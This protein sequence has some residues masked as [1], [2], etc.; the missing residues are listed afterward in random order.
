[1]PRA[2]GKPAR[3][4]TAFETRLYELCSA[5]PPGR[6]TTY[7]QMAAVLASAPRACGQVRQLSA[8]QPGRDAVMFPKLIRGCWLFLRR[9]G[10]TPLRRPCPATV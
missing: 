5:I 1:M 6:V 3:P 2:G 8:K 10:G 9:C 4:P 7:G